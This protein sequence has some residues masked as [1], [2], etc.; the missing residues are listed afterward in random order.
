MRA[1]IFKNHKDQNHI[2]FFTSP[3]QS[4]DERRILLCGLRRLALKN[5][6]KICV[7]RE[8]LTFKIIIYID[9]LKQGRQ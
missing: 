5:S 7:N 8:G 4:F 6:A 2:Y 1:R 3:K 9:L